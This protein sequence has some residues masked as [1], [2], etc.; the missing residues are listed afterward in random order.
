M[1]MEL[2][3][4][5]PP[6]RARTLEE[7]QEII[8]LLWSMLGELSKR[9]EAESK[10]IEGLEE[11]L[12]TNSQNSSKPPSMD[13]RGRK[14]AKRKQAKSKRKPGGQP[15][16]EGKAHELLPPEEVN[17]VKVCYPQGV[18]DCGHSVTVGGLYY[19]HQVHELPEVKP[20]ITEYR[21]LEGRC[22]GCGKTHVASLP[23]GVSACLLGPRAIALVGSLTGA[24]RLSQRLVQE[25]LRDV[26]GLKLSLGTV[27]QTEEVI[28]AALLP[29][30]EEAKDHI[31]Q[32]PVAHCDETGHQEKGE[33]QWMWVAIAAWVSV[34]VV[35]A[36]RS[37]A[38]AKELLGEAFAGILISDRG[39]AYTW[40]KVTQRQLCWSHL[41][42]DFTRIS[43]RSGEAGRIGEAL[44]AD[45]KKMF[46]YWHWVKN[47]TMT[48]E[49]FQK[50]MKAIRMGVE[51]TLTQGA[52]CGEAKTRNTC[53][54]LLKLRQALW[55]FVDTEGV[56]PTNN[57][58]ERTLRGYVIF[59]KVCL[60]TQSARGST[61]LE[62]IM[63]TVGSCRLQGRNVLDFLTQAV[64][65]HFGNGPIPSLVP[66]ST[67]NSIPGAV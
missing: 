58:A 33:K 36:S 52:R 1:P 23:S 15:G 44:L 38:V 28:S 24:Y 16:H 20:V 4:T 40:L 8:D 7:A 29:V 11:R 62:R 66:H 59:R 45:V 48:R 27:S 31:R 35:S 57:V 60:G 67:D 3:F 47:D 43:E 13:G 32:A 51:A 61:Y 21:L 63:T 22:D 65:A 6:P 25:L 49:R 12:R 9:V 18:C 5:G 2:D 46:K 42:R 26:C 39:S 34:F 64:K 50:R 55:T 53:K 54:R 14:K 17:E 56:E 19:R 10:R 41:L 30:T 37:A